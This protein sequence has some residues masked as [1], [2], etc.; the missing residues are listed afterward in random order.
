MKKALPT[1]AYAGWSIHGIA[2]SAASLPRYTFSDV[3]RDKFA[4]SADTLIELI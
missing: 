4:I 3:P 1:G 2:W